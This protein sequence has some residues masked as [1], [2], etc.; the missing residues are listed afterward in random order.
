MILHH[1]DMRE[2]LATFDPES[3]DAIVTD[4]PYGIGFMGRE[5][6]SF[7]P[8]AVA[9]RK[10]SERRKETVRTSERYPEKVS[11]R[12]QGGGVPIYYDESVTGNQ[13]FQAWVEEWATECLCVIKPGGYLL[14]CGGSRTFHR[15]TSGVEDAGFEI[16]DVLSWLHGSGFPKSHNLKGDRDGWGTALKPAWEPIVMARKPFKGTVANNVLEHGTGAL[17]IDACRI[18]GPGGVGRVGEVSQTRR[19]KES[20]SVPFAMT[21]GPRGGDPMGRW[22]ANVVLDEAAAELLDEQSGTLTSGSWNG[23]RTKPKHNNIYGT[24][25]DDADSPT[26]GSS[27]GASRFY[28]TAKASR[29]ERGEGNMHPT[30]K[31]I[32]LM[33]WLVRMVTPPNGTVLD[34]FMGSGTTGVAAFLEG[35]SFIGIEQEAEYLEIARARI[36]HA[37]RCGRQS[38]FDLG[39]TA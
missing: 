3:I 14:V 28:Y 26:T 12:S 5:W 22:P 38:T 19:Y 34:P 31:P 23:K 16:R 9:R 7:D 8:S 21:P 25:G 15:L 37:E 11:T 24:Y 30:V 4:P 2:V 39:E 35:F 27:G 32:S 20:G 29:S 13:R 18:E 6:D 1:G 10:E 36:K 33:R 17:N